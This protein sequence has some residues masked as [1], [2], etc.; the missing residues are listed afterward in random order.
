MS[1]RKPNGTA[2]SVASGVATGAGIS[3]TFT[4]IGSWILGRMVETEK[5]PWDQIG[6]WILPLIMFS[7]AVGSSAAVKKIK[8]KKVLSCLLTGVTYFSAL[9]IIT[10]LCFGG[11][12]EAVP[13]TA[14]LIAAGSVLPVL[15]KNG[16]RNAAKKRNR[17]IYNR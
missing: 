13:E 16:E 17:G 6:Y 3:I 10:A 7:A 14:G 8:V 12:Y 11:E 9:L 15:I 5:I 1:V 2:S 4:L